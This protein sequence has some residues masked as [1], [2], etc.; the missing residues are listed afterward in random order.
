MAKRDTYDICV[1][2]LYDDVT[3]LS[4]LPQQQRDK[5]LRIRSGYTIMLEFPSKKDREIILHLQNQFGIERSAAYEDLRLIKD[6]LGSINKQSKDWHRF[7]FNYR[8]EKAY[9]MAELQQ[10]PIAMDKCNNTYGKYNQLDKEDAERI[11]WEEIIP[12]LYEPTDDPSVL[13]IKPIP[14]IREKIAATKKKYME[15]IEDVTYEDIDIRELEKYA[16]Q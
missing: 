1:Q 4:H 14:N 12:Q 10:D 7:R 3:K 16:D 13:G 11:P 9:N 5:L 15:D 2:H 6:L 8:N